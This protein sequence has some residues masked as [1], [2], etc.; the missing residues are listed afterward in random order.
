LELDYD[1]SQPRWREWALNSLSTSATVLQIVPKL[2]GTLDGV[3]DYALKVADKL[4]QLYRCD[5]IFAAREF[6]SRTNIH[7][8]GTIS[9][10]SLDRAAA[11]QASLG[12][13]LHWVNYGYQKRG[14]PFA[15]LRVL[16]D[17]RTQHRGSLL[18]VF[19][20]LCAS[21][22]PWRSAF[23]LRPWQVHITRS[24]AQLSDACIVSSEV[25]LQELEQLVPGIKASVHPVVSNFGE[26]EL[27]V[28]QFERR[29]P[30]R[31]VI[32]GGTGLVER[33][34]RSFRRTINSIPEPC[35]PRELCV[36]GGID[37]PAARVMLAELANIRVNYH[38]QIKAEEASDIL[39][40]CAFAWVDYFHRPDVLT[41]AILKS[42]AFAAACAHGVI[43]VLPH[44][45]TVVALQG[46]RL[47]G[48]YFVEP[49]RAKLPADP[50][51]VAADIYAWYQRNV[52]SDHLVYGIARA[53]NLVSEAAIH[54]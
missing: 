41:S 40:T 53:L 43:P 28:D 23:W 31:W 44:S 36:L 12:I 25:T 42:T 47:P 5:T 50:A 30:H 51:K 3:G 52:S 26:P 10:D 21:G 9:L 35:S 45:G 37:N 22:P 14:V 27:E 38:P 34:I 7:G 2:P 48:L 6:D 11:A 32:C 17:M 29:D 4:R 1:L 24:I 15:L 20:E 49:M 16:R 39:S 33:S 13:I 54:H 19:H 46:D 8:F 18:T